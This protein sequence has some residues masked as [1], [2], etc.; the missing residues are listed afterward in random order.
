[1]A[2]PEVSVAET[3]PVPRAP[4]LAD[5]VLRRIWEARRISRAEIA[6][7]GEL[8]RSTVSEIVDEL[9]RTGL[10]AEA[11]EGTS[12][13]GR[14][15]IV[16][17]FQDG[18]RSIL[19]VDIGA[20][21]V[22]VA[23][24]DLRGKVLAWETRDFPARDDPAGAGRLVVELCEACVASPT[25]RGSRLVGV[26]VGVPSPVDPRQPERLSAIA[27][28]SWGGR[29]NLDDLRS[30]FRVPVR[31]DNDA[32]L[33]ALAEHWWGSAKNLSNFAYVKVAT[34]IGSGHFVNGAIS[35]GA[36]GVAG[37]LGHVAIDPR[38]ALCNCG[39]RG[40][41][42]TYIGTQALLDRATSLRPQ[43]PESRLSGGTSPTILELEKAALADD[44]LA[45][46]VFHEAAEYLG[47]AI[48]GMVNL[49]NPSAV[50]IGGG[51]A[52]LGERLLAPLRET[53]LRRTFVGASA[54][55]EIRTSDLGP[56]DVAI[57]AA[58]L[59]L[60]AALQDPSLFHTGARA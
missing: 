51:I 32:N 55:A 35:R 15:P 44:P 18:A 13:G 3:K 56:Q 10:V 36:T 33:G 20:S 7:A 58:T 34:G 42:Q 22:S 30:R 12:R 2:R 52:R 40:C 25:A 47:T 41:L 50:I 53:V 1:M 43:Y 28:P 46:A 24:T 16:L 27:L 14:R 21:H 45:L 19:G 23:L 49:M 48:A 31:I 9:L 38:G 54:A 6:R 59:V 17:E 57:G 8:S 29:L 39:N 11:G 60:D 37:E 5:A 26:G 4:R